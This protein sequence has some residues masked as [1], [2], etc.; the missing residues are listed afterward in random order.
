MEFLATTHGYVFKYNTNK[1]KANNQILTYLFHVLV[2]YIFL[3]LSSWY[4]F[5]SVLELMTRK[6]TQVLLSNLDL[7]FIFQIYLHKTL[8]KGEIYPS[9][10]MISSSFLEFRTLGHNPFHFEVMR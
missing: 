1:K 9:I 7:F 3:S 6:S 10:Q 4:F 2:Q 5:N 8:G